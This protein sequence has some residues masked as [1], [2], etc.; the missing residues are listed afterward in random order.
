M[1]SAQHELRTAGSAVPGGDVRILP[2]STERPRSRPPNEPAES[3]LSGL[4]RCDCSDTRSDQNESTTMS[5]LS[6][7]GV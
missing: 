6:S 5:S 7:F 3:K 1:D 2:E 4:M